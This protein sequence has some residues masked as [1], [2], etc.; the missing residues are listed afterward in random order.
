MP[1]HIAIHLVR[2]S[3]Q[4]LLL[5]VLVVLVPLLFVTAWA[6]VAIGDLAARREPQ[7]G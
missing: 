2:L 7:G 1:S 6:H 3:I 5:P 4:L